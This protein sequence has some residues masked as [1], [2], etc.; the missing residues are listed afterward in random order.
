MATVRT[1]AKQE[2]ARIEKVIDADTLL[3]TS[4]VTLY[5]RDVGNIPKALDK[6]DRAALVKRAIAILST[7]YQGKIVRYINTG[8]DSQGRV[9]ATNIEVIEPPPTSPDAINDE[10]AKKELNLYQ[11]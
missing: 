4:R 1:R 11:G 9:I 7:K 5:L 3:T 10:E 2:A 6:E 8:V